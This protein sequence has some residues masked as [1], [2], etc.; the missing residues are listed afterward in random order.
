MQKNFKKKYSSKSTR[1]E[2][3]N[4]Y[5]QDKAFLDDFQKSL[6][7]CTK[8]ASA[9]EGLMY[10]VIIYRVYLVSHMYICVWW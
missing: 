8:V 10:I 4:E 2:L 9:L 3:C 1:Q 5:K 6:S 7:P